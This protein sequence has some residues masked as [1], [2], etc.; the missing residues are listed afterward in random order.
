MTHLE[1][2]LV[3]M[4]HTAPPLAVYVFGCVSVWLTNVRTR[5]EDKHVEKNKKNAHTATDEKKTQ[6]REAYEEFNKCMI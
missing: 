1:R 6:K 5:Y 4:Q 2:F 3:R